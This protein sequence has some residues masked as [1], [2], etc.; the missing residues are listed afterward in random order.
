MD[1]PAI[2]LESVLLGL[3]TGNPFREVALGG[4]GPTPVPLNHYAEQSNFR[5][6]VLRAEAHI[7]YPGRYRGSTPLRERH[8]NEAT[9]V[10]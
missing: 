3:D 4:P 5:R 8:H 1:Q 10:N 7:L 6:D 9:E 2:A